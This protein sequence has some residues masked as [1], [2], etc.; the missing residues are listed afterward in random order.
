MGGRAVGVP[1]PL[2]LL[3][4]LGGVR[5]SAERS[6]WEVPA[7][8]TPPPPASDVSKNALTGTLPAVWE[9]GTLGL[10][11]LGGNPRLAGR[12]ADLRWRMPRLYTLCAQRG[13]GGDGWDPWAARCG[14]PAPQPTHP[15]ARAPP[16]QRP[17]RPPA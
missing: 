14:A 13:R 9:S 7:T 5:T 6:T 12:V 10:L 11:H 4:P 15:H 17:D 3:P 8:P 2:P 16:S 1:K